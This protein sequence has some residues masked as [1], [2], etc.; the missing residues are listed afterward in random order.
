MGG[1]LLPLLESAGHRVRCL[2]RRAGGSVGWYHADWP[3]TLRGSVDR[4]AGGMGTRRG[5][6][7]RSVDV[8][9][10]AT[11]DRYRSA[12]SDP[13]RAL[14]EGFHPLKHALRFDAEILE[15]LSPDPGQ[16]ADLAADLAPDVSERLASLLAEIPAGLY[17][18]L[19]PRPPDSGV[20][21]LAR[22]PPTDP[23][24]I[25]AL[26]APRPVVLLEEP[27][28]LGNLGAAVRAAAAA[29]AAGVLATGGHDPWHPSALRGSAGLH[30]ALPVAGLDDLGPIVSRHGDAAGSGHA[31]AR[32]ARAIPPASG[33]SGRRPLVAVDPDGERPV[34]GDVPSRAILAFGSERGGLSPELLRA[35][36]LRLRIPMREG[37]SSLNLATSVAVVLYTWR[38]GRVGGR[39]PA[40]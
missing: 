22:R 2:A 8:N 37:V 32:S 33:D 1:R 20:V 35:A 4:L 25:L 38:L 26:P 6:D 34:A 39:P 30:F 27:S 12:R 7:D 36:D 13:D 16:V 28:H 23:G 31:P 29:G 15:A 10:Q 3:W 19:S 14:L 9:R 18:E 21:A 24:E 11:I 40:G 17:A 5:R